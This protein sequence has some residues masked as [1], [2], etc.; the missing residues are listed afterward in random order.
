MATKTAERTKPRLSNLDEL[1]KLDESSS[2]IAAE[3]A[4]II[5]ASE[6]PNAHC[7]VK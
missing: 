5:N 7:K 3:P 2:Q 1:F 6:Q 4:A